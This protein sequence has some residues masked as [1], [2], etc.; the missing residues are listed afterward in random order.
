MIAYLDS[1]AFIKLVKTEDES[2]ALI[3]CLRDWSD[4]VSSRL[5]RVEVLR[6]ARFG[7]DDTVAR[8][9]TLLRDVALLPLSATIVDR[10][11]EVQPESVRSLDA[12]HL[13]TALSLGE[14]LGTLIA[15][16]RRLVEAAKAA[17]APVLSPGA[18]NA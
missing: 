11:I 8:A 18:A 2:E 12:V 7:G 17:G 5:L 9:E 1:S 6:A 14:D 16:D 3:E 10:A 4:R 13:A 15:Y